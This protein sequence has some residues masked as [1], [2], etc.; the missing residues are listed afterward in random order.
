[1]PVV[2]E[3]IEQVGV[4]AHSQHHVLIA[5][6]GGALVHDA[7]GVPSLNANPMNPVAIG[8]SRRVVAITQQRFPVAAVEISGPA[9]LFEVREPRRFLSFRGMAGCAKSRQPERSLLDTPLIAIFLRPPP[10]ED[11]VR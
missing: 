3:I 6:T 10:S 9:D 2:L 5:V 11:S 4:N 8:T 7:G 1:V